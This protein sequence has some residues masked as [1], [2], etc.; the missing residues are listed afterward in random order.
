MGTNFF[1]VIAAILKISFLTRKTFQ[2]SSSNVFSSDFFLVSGNLPF[3]MDFLECVSTTCTS[4]FVD[5]STK[6]TIFPVSTG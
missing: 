2:K 6:K 3:K 4:L 5:F 1:T